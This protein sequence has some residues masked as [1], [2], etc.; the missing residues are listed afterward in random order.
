[1]HGTLVVGVDGSPASL[2]ALRWSAELAGRLD[3]KVEVVHAWTPVTRFHAPYARSAHRPTTEEERRRAGRLLD[4]SVA[5]L[6]ALQPDADVRAVLVEGP[7][8]PALLHCA[9]HAAALALGRGPRR[10]PGQPAL[11]PVARECARAACCPVITVP[12]P[13]ATETAA[14]TGRVAGRR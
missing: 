1:M 7:T 10:G 6:L 9:E 14:G 5:G 12:E 13:A 8:V 11:G 3:L 2:A 4:E